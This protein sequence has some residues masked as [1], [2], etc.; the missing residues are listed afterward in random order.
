[1]GSYAHIRD[2]IAYPLSYRGDPL[3]STCKEKLVDSVQMQAKEKQRA[4]S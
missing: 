4:N 2:I 1:M 3:K